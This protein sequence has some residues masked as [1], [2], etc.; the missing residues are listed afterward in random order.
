MISILIL[1][2]IIIITSIICMIVIRNKIGVNKVL[3]EIVH[4]SNYE[5][6]VFKIYDKS[7]ADICDRLIIVSPFDWYI[8]A[9][10]H[11]L[12]ILN[13]EGGAS[14]PPNNTPAI[15]VT[16]DNFTATCLRISFETILKDYT[17]D[18]PKI[19]PYEI[20]DTVF[21]ILSALN[22]LVSDWITFDTTNVSKITID[23]IRPNANDKNADSLSDNDDEFEEVH[24]ERHNY[25]REKRSISK[26]NLI[27]LTNTEK[28]LKFTHKPRNLLQ[29]ALLY[30]I[31]QNYY[32]R[33]KKKSQHNKRILK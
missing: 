3:D 19:V 27:K 22:L 20:K 13:P 23:H 32:T 24:N 17:A 4:K 25:F 30:H 6:T 9:T 28:N 31:P 2:L 18:V 15:Q 21:T 16:R 14:C 5:S 10:Q 33:K 11:N 7:T 29:K 12:Y 26:D 8:W 1:I